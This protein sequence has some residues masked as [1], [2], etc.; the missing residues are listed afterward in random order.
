MKHI[1]EEK[2]VKFTPNVVEISEVSIGQVAV[3]GF[4]DNDSRMYKF[5]H[6]LPYSQGNALLPH[7]NEKRKSLHE[8]YGHINYKY[9]YSLRK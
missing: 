4:A 1:G 3:V 8:R 6:F 9:L 7:S 2:R 5:S